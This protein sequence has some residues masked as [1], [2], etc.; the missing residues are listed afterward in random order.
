MAAILNIRVRFIFFLSLCLFAI[1]VFLYGTLNRLSIDADNTTYTHNT[2]KHFQ[3]IEVQR[4][5]KYTISPEE[6]FLAYFSHSGYHN[7]RIALENALLLAKLLNRTLLLPPVMLGRPLPWLAFDIL[8]RRLFVTTK[9]G[10]EYCKDISENYPLPA[11]CLDYFSYT[12]VSWDFLV[13]MD[14]INKWH[15]IMDRPEHSY[16]WL[17]KNLNI[18]QNNDIYFVKDSSRL[19]YRIYDTPNSTIPYSKYSRKM[20][21]SD[22]LAIDKKVIHFGSLFGSFRVVPEFPTN[23]EHV[24]FIR[25]HLIPTNS[26]IQ[27]AANRIIN[28]LGGSKNFIGLHIRVSDGFFMKFAKPNIDNIYHRIIDTFTNLSPQEVDILEGGTHDSDI[29]VDDTVDLGDPIF[30]D[31]STATKSYQKNID[32]NILKEVKCQKPF[33]PTDKGV[34]TIIYIATDAE[35]PRTNPLLF[36]FFNTFPCVFVLDDF[37]QELAEMKSARNVEDKT[38]LASY[39]IPMLDAMISSKG[40]RFYGTPKSTFSNYIDKT[41]HPLYTGKELLIELM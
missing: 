27:N 16:E 35:S 34:N 19:D 36:K 9:T 39:L 3:D 4:H 38:P 13:D 14:P 24:I 6:K 31:F 7:Q 21:I 33:H 23:L 28:K 18:N 5:K 30:R 37:D 32:L 40:F 12:I 17:E 8:Y 11:E 41:L 29:L 10:I 20:E 2:P 22:L 26:L 1:A 15:R 25:K